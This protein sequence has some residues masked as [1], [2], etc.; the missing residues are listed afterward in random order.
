MFR[1]GGCT[2]GPDGSIVRFGAAQLGNQH[3]Q[4]RATSQAFFPDD[5]LVL[6]NKTFQDQRKLLCSPLRLQ[7]PSPRLGCQLGFRIVAFVSCLPPLDLCSVTGSVPTRLVRISV[8][9]IALN[10]TALDRTIL[11]LSLSIDPSAHPL[12]P[13]VIISSQP[14]SRWRIPRLFPRP[15]PGTTCY[16][17]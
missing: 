3:G 6:G 16:K 7:S 9:S 13:S 10:L 5:L 11:P 12:S 17:T 15:S 4:S 1:G 2:G 8:S 14:Q